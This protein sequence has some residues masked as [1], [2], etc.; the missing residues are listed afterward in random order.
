MKTTITMRRLKIG[1][2]MRERKYKER[3]I[4][5]VIRLEGNWLQEAGFRPGESVY[6]FVQDGKI[7]LKTA[8]EDPTEA[9]AIKVFN[10]FNDVAA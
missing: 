7:T 8:P 4:Y 6:L 2:G 10:A 5:P 9:A 3:T 1:D